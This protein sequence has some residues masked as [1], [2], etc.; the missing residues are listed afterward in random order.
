MG[1]SHVGSGPF[2]LLGMQIGRRLFDHGKGHGSA[3]AFG[4][5]IR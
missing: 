1:W 5:C 3:V 4:L 2:E